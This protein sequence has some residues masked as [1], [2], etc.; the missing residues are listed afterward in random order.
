MDLA[1]RSAC[2]GKGK[3]PRGKIIHRYYRWDHK[4]KTITNKHAQQPWYIHSDTGS[5]YLS[6][7]DSFFKVYNSRFVSSWSLK[8]NN[9]DRQNGGCEEQLC[10]LPNSNQA[11]N[12][13]MALQ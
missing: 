9:P 2:M 7:Q 3:G 8:R 4:Q 5:R 11:A 6:M 12:H 10:I 1:E 13:A